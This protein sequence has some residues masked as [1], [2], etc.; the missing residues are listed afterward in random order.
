[1]DSSFQF[2]AHFSLMLTAQVW[3]LPSSLTLPFPNLLPWWMDCLPVVAFLSYW[4]KLFLK[5]PIV[6]GVFDTAPWSKSPMNTSLKTCSWTEWT[7]SPHIS[8]PFIIPSTSLCS[9]CCL[10]CMKFYT[11]TSWSKIFILL[12][13]LKCAEN[14]HDTANYSKY[15]WLCPW[16]CSYVM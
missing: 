10:P 1:M 2:I 6:C 12:F 8:T 14:L 7:Y 9:L 16:L 4:F 5:M 13:T 11:V 15:Q 3:L